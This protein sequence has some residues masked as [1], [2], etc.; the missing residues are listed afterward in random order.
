MNQI[1]TVHRSSFS[2]SFRGLLT[3]TLF[4][5][6]LPGGLGR[7]SGICRAARGGGQEW[8]ED[9]EDPGMVMLRTTGTQEDISWGPGVSRG[10]VGMLVC[11][12]SWVSTWSSFRADGAGAGAETAGAGTGTGA[13]GDAEVVERVRALEDEPEFERTAVERAVAVGRAGEGGMPEIGARVFS[14]LVAGLALRSSWLA[15]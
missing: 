14:V 1:L 11:N 15:A 13:R 7:R 3:R 8:I 4:R 2:W 9:R 5:G 10:V 12:S 6:R